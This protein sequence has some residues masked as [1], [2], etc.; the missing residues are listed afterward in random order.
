MRR[1]V[2]VVAV[3]LLVSGCANT[4]VV[5]APE[6]SQEDYPLSQSIDEDEVEVLEE[7]EVP[8][9]RVPVEISL[10]IRPHHYGSFDSVQYSHGSRV[11]Y[12]TTFE[13]LEARA[14]NIVRGRM[15][16][17]ARILMEFRSI[18][19]PDQHTGGVN[20]V[21]FEVLEVIKGN[22]IGIGETIRIIEPY[23][24]LDRV[25]FTH[26]NYMPSIPHQEYFFFLYYQHTGL[27][28]DGSGLEEMAGAFWTLHGDRSRFP[29][30][31]NKAGTHG[32]SVYM[33][34]F[35]ASDLGL[36]PYAN[37]DIYLSIWQEVLDAFISRDIRPHHY[38][39]F[40]RVLYSHP[41]RWFAPTTLEDLTSEFWA[42]NIVRGRLAD[43]ARIV[44]ERPNRTMGA[45]LV[46]LEILEVIQGDLRV[47]ET[48]TIMEWYVIGGREL[49]TSSNYMPSTPHKEYFFFLEPQR[50]IPTVEEGTVNVFGVAYGERGRFPIPASGQDLDEIDLAL[51]SYA[52]IEIY[53]SLWQEVLDTFIS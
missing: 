34:N 20:L 48:I 11:F 51:G 52:N 28:L 29:A 35:S 19:N 39:A 17:D 15:G 13:G 2:I 25:L 37:I 16:D 6:N 10:D 40:D 49:R 22:Q 50:T 27:G 44:F 46:S 32:F 30:P 21:S 24:I 38:G 1:F 31:I 3:A 4:Q 47:G 43:D 7:I 33:P 12:E 36:S 18:V 26:G 41:T 5:E 42:P 23:Y 8:E 45:N 53:M 14:P 9:H